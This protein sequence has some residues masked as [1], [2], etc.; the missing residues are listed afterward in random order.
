MHVC[1]E[2]D[3]SR[4]YLLSSMATASSSLAADDL[5]CS[6]YQRI[7]TRRS[8]EG[9][10]AFWSFRTPFFSGLVFISP[11]QPRRS[12]PSSRSCV[13]YVRANSISRDS[14]RSAATYKLFQSDPPSRFLFLVSPAA[15]RV[16][17]E[18]R[19]RLIAR[20]GMRVRNS[21]Y[22]GPFQN[23]RRHPCLS[24]SS[25]SFLFSFQ[26]RNESADE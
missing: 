23:S 10:R 14:F 6:K 11:S 9:S 17:S 12:L 22:V 25:L 7:G 18:K 16:T 19:R 4:R 2:F 20:R 1:T 26:L 15:V 3:K 13:S 8:V 21:T 5:R 24:F